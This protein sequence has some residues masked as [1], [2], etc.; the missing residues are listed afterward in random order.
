MMKTPHFMLFS[1]RENFVAK[2][3]YEPYVVCLPGDKNLSYVSSKPTELVSVC[4]VQQ[5]N[6]ENIA[7][8]VGGL[9]SLLLKEEVL[10]PVSLVFWKTLQVWAV[11]GGSAGGRV[12][13]IEGQGDFDRYCIAFVYAVAEIHR[14]WDE[15][16]LEP[17]KGDLVEVTKAV[18][19]VIYFIEKFVNYHFC[20]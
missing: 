3:S 1:N 15:N 11:T 19:E 20:E 6:L 10:S 14:W 16:V 12:I 8:A 7:T 5:F 4:G 9:S 17:T 2:F 13:E 18:Q